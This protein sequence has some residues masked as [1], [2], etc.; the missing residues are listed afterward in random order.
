MLLEKLE[1]FGF[2]SFAERTQIR[3]S[4]GI[5]AVVGPN[6]CG[7]SNISDAVR[8]ALGEQNVRNLRGRVLQDIIFKGT[9]EVEPMGMAE[10]ALHMDN[11]SQQL[12]TE[13]SQV[14]IRRRAF[15]S[16]ES[17]FSINK[18]ACRLKDIRNLFL[19][20]GLGSTAYVVIEREMIDEI[21]AD[22]DQSRRFLLDEASGITRYKQR[23]KEALLKLDGVERDLTRVEDALEIEEREVR[24]LAYQMGKTRKYQR[25]TTKIRDLEVALARLVWRELCADASGESGRLGKEERQRE[26]TQTRAR[27]LEA[28]QEKLR[29]DLL[30]LSRK[31]ENARSELAGVEADLSVA[32]E[33]S[34]VRRERIRALHEQIDGLKERMVQA[35]ETCRKAE[36]E[37]TLLLPQVEVHAGELAASQRT[38]SAAENEWRKGERSLQAAKEELTRHQQLR[39]DSVRRDSDADHRIGVLESRLFDLETNGEKVAKQVDALRARETEISGWLDRTRQRHEQLVGERRV[40]QERRQALEEEIRGCREQ[41]E[42]LSA[43]LAGPSEE[44]A[45]IDSRLHLMSEQARSYEGFREGVAQLLSQKEEV[46]GVLGVASELLVVAPEWAERLAPALREMTDWVVTDSDESAWRAIEWLRNKGLGQVTF[47]PLATFTAKSRQAEPSADRDREAGHRISD[48]LPATAIKARVP[49]ATALV[50]FVA[51]RIIPMPDAEGVPPVGERQPGRRWVT[52]AGEV[53]ASEGWLAVGGRESAEARLWDRPQEI[54]RM[55]EHLAELAATCTALERER[56]Q[57]TERAAELESQVASRSGDTEEQKREI[58]NL[59]GALLQKEAEERLVREEVARL[60]EE[61]ERVALRRK[62]QERDLTELQADRLRVTEESVSTETLFREASE[63]VD[64][65][66]VEKDSLAESL[67]EKKM[68][69]LLAET[70]LR[71]VRG[72][73]EQHAAEIAETTR[74]LEAMA[75]ERERARDEIAQLQ[76]R[77]GEFEREEADLLSARESRNQEVNR[78][79]QERGRLEDRLGSIERDLRGK[80]RELSEFEDALREN[81]VRLARLE[82]QKENLSG[83]ILEQYGIDLAK[84]EARAAVAN[85]PVAEPTVAGVSE[86]GATVAENAPLPEPEEALGEMS[87]EEARARAA[88]LRRDRDRLGLVNPLAIEDYEKKKDHVR[89][90]KDQRD[91]LHKSKESLLEAIERINTEARHLFQGTFEKVQENLSKTFETLF[92]GGEA[93]LRL[94]G[95]DPLEAEIEIMARPRG[96][97]LESIH[98][99]S[100]GERALTATALLFALYLV[101]PSPFCLLDEVDAPLD[102]ANIDR[103]LNLIRTFSEKT[104]FIVITHNKRTMEVADTLYGVTMQE[105]GISKIV[106]VR[107]D[108]GDLVTDGDDGR[109]RVLDGMPAE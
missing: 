55:R 105:P 68:G 11:A 18:S 73:L 8:W 89:F 100:S 72:R 62:A 13:Y 42:T 30:D 23:R 91:D 58:D 108:G 20:T 48:G 5:T 53:F 69:A 88:A 32:R 2:K 45:R 36:K 61:R 70:H 27:G 83:R 12:A 10:I 99:L 82:A 38:A 4:P 79:D 34:L 59:S 85:E 75:A 60:S 1:L 15:R 71:D 40:A 92:P 104:Q 106:S 81:E 95:E 19:D 21:L 56:A 29:L 98:L 52:A 96:K 43:Q 28:E 51:E 44:R 46:P 76:E 39:I 97:R 16:G 109:P 41:G 64:R 25:L 93:E 80:R 14:T 3:F 6:G 94:T 33:E 78:L 66:S 65:L 101:K 22:R 77:L 35:T 24:S 26:A 49:A 103:F 50:D 31:L 107:L 7:K 102:D 67:S 37:R 54:A 57:V 47:F 63:E 84:I 86:G 74:H 17:E 87:R 9:R 90:I